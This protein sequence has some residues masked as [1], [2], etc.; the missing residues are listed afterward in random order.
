MAR[1]RRTYAREFKIEAVKLVTKQGYSVAEAVASQFRG[2][3]VP[4]PVGVP[5]VFPPP[6]PDIRLRLEHQPLPPRAL[7]LVRAVREQMLVKMLRDR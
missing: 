2:W 3:A 7:A 4:Q 1:K 6:L 5:A